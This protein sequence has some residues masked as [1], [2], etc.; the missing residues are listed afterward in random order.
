[1][2]VRELERKDDQG[3]PHNNNRLWV[4]PTQFKQASRSMAAKLS[5]KNVPETVS[6]I[7]QSIPCS[8]CP[9]QVK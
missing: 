9:Q 7:N 6:P 5:G 8:S 2:G 3:E 4:Y 1:M